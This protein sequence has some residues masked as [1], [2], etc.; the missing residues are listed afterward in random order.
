MPL[1]LRTISTRAPQRL[2]VPRACLRSLTFYQ[3]FL[4]SSS[5]PAASD[6]DAQSKA[7][8]RTRAA[9]EFVVHMAFA[10]AVFT[11]FAVLIG[12]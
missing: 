2:R 3:S 9:L 5:A 12:L 4:F 1:L 7:A 6:F 10:I 11:G 8:F